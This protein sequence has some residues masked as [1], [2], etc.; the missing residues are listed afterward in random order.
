MVVIMIVILIVI[1]IV[2]M[3]SGWRIKVFSIT[4]ISGGRDRI[5]LDTQEWSKDQQV[6]DIWQKLVGEKNYFPFIVKLL[7]SLIE[8]I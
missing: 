3:I 5:G 2:I 4:M 7:E 6:G 1:I 8:M